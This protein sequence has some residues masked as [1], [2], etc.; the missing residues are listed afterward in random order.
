MS[1]QPLTLPVDPNDTESALMLA[2]ALVRI[3]AI[4]AAECQAMTGA[5][6]SDI[7]KT[8]N[9]EPCKRLAV[10]IQVQGHAHEVAAQMDLY[11]AQLKLRERLSDDEISTSALLAISQFLF[12]IGGMKERRQVKVAEAGKPAFNVV[13]ILESDPPDVVEAKRRQVAGSGIVIDLSGSASKNKG[14]VDG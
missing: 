12:N 6:Q 1:N 9:S 11:R 4:T 5:V 2:C 7:I 10:Q 13:T 8:I 14:V 3:K